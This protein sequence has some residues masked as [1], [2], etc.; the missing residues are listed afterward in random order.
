VG[1]AAHAATPDRGDSGA[2]RHPELLPAFA[3]GFASSLAYLRF[4]VLT[5]WKC[6]RCG[7]DHLHCECKPA[8]VKILL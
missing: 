3:A 2:V 5:Q 1:R 7:D 6:R 8:W 4:I